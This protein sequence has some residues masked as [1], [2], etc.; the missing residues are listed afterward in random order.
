MAF[1]LREI[2]DSEAH[3]YSGRHFWNSKGKVRLWPIIAVDHE[4]NMYLVSTGGGEGPDRQPDTFIFY[5]R[6]LYLTFTGDYNSYLTPN[7]KTYYFTIKTMSIPLNL[8]DQTQNILQLIYEAIRIFSS[9][10]YTGESFKDHLYV[11]SID[12]VSPEWVVDEQKGVIISGLGPDLGN[13]DP[14]DKKIVAERREIKKQYSLGARITEHLYNFRVFVADAHIDLQAVYHLEDNGDKLIWQ[15]KESAIPRD[16]NAQ[17][18]KL[19]AWIRPALMA[20]STQAD[21]VKATAVDL[22][23]LALSEGPGI[24]QTII[25]NKFYPFF[26]LDV[27]KFWLRSRTN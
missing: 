25:G 21:P 17:K 9:K 5:M 12:Y 19:L 24:V 15:V 11:E 3:L 13:F 6:G 7:D 1:V 2:P 16:F 27:S 18:E 23:H 14:Y 22:S 8:E 4:N 26:K 10:A 20:Y